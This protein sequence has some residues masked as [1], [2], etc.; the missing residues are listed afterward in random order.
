MLKALG[1]SVVLAT[2]S[3]AFLVP[4]VYYKGFHVALAACTTEVGS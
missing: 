2:I 1:F 3:A 4:F